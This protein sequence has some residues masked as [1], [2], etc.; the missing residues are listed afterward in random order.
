MTLRDLGIRDPNF[1]ISI[2]Q[3]G[4]W[5]RATRKDS[6][7]ESVDRKRSLNLPLCSGLYF[8]TRATGCIVDRFTRWLCMCDRW[9]FF[10][11]SLN[12]H[13]TRLYGPLF[14]YTSRPWASVAAAVI[15]GHFCLLL[16][17]SF[18]HGNLLNSARTAAECWLSFSLTLCPTY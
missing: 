3:V 4:G 18:Q 1:Q 13:C 15:G 11:F 7:R 10:F 17:Y 14:W 9:A 5:A 2:R 16:L 6:V 8:L 12:I